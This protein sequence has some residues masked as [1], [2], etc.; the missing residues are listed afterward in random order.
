MLF[1]FVLVDFGG[2][3]VDD[4]EVLAFVARILRRG[5]PEPFVLGVVEF[6]LP[7]ARRFAI[8]LDRFKAAIIKGSNA[9]SV[10]NSKNV[11]KLEKQQRSSYDLYSCPY[12]SIQ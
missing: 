7:R 5:L 10:F 4:D 8:S 12:A 6:V 11:R 9:S 3:F 1:E 2:G